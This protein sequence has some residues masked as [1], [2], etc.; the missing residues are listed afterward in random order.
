VDKL[1]EEGRLQRAVENQRLRA[2]GASIAKSTQH[3]T[4]TSLR[5]WAHF[6]LNFGLDE[7][8]CEK[9]GELM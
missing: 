2:R 6:C 1:R 5:S 8:C 3:S 4:I 7:G 9:N